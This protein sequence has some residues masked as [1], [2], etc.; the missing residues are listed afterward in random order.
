MALYLFLNIEAEIF[1]VA[2]SFVENKASADLVVMTFNMHAM[3]KYMDDNGEKPDV[4]IDFIR[5]KILM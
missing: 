1:T 2:K 3:G 5:V 4:I